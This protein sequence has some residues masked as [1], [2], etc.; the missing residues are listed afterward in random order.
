MAK[1][2]KSLPQE[3]GFVLF[4]VVY[5]DGSRSSNRRVPVELLG[6]LDGDG[7]ARDLITEQDEAIA[8]KAGRPRR[9]IESL[10]RSPPAPLKPP[11]E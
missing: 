10:L 3:R 1:R 6:G 9:E 2:I 5:A 4:D 8:Q 7:P 11:R